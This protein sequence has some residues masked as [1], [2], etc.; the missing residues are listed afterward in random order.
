MEK[1][2]LAEEAV[3]VCVCD[4]NWQ[5]KG[6]LAKWGLLLRAC[7]DVLLNCKILFYYEKQ[8]QFNL[9]RYHIFPKKHNKK[10]I[11]FLLL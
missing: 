6:R 7:V 1:P 3:C 4:Y 5:K 10:N 9:S 2:A 11:L 8:G